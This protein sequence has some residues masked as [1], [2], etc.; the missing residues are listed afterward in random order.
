VLIGR[1]TSFSSFRRPHISE[2]L[3]IFNAPLCRLHHLVISVFQFSA[4]TLLPDKIANG[5]YD[6]TVSASEIIQELPKLSDAER[7]AVLDKLRELAQ[8]DD[9]RWE[10]IINEPTPRP[11]LQAFIEQ[12]T[13]EGSE[14]LDLNR[15]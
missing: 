5:G 15:M 7:Q 11:K 8:V 14:P 3:E 1:S 4:L 13:A 6:L 9:D 12:A 2:K 10:E